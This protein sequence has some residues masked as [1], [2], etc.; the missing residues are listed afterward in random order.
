MHCQVFTLEAS[1]DVDPEAARRQL[2]KYMSTFR[3]R[4]LLGPLPLPPA[5][6]GSSG[7]GV[8]QVRAACCPECLHA[9]SLPHALA[10]PTA[11]SVR[12][13]SQQ[14]WRSRINAH[15]IPVTLQAW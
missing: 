10:A 13:R 7:A 11:A 9:K 14:L 8:A 15:F 2:Q 3:G 4:A 12:L 1:P 6:A 5:K